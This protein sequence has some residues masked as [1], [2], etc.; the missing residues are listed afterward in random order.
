MAEAAE[1][2]MV[3]SLHQFHHERAH[4]GG[5][6]DDTGLQRAPL[7]LGDV[8]LLAEDRAAGRD[9][10]ADGSGAKEHLDAF[11]LHIDEPH[12]GAGPQLHVLGREFAFEGL[13]SFDLLRAK[14]RLGFEF[15]G[16]GLVHLFRITFCAA[17][18]FSDSHGDS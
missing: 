3:I 18:F 14:H 16:P 5:V 2:E 6:I 4:E 8:G 13:A 11:A 9:D 7:A 17:A 12:L 15:F 1:L 10:D